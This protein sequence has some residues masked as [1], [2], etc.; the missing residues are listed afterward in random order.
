MVIKQPDV[1]ICIRSDDAVSMSDASE[2][3]ER[4]FGFPPKGSSPN[5]IPL[6]ILAEHM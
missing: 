4:R 5:D 1:Q 2:P 3:P 6:H